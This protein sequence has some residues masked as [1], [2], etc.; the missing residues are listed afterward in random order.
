MG[1]RVPAGYAEVT[2]RFRIVGD[3]EEMLT[4]W[5]I[6]SEFNTLFTADHA[7]QLADVFGTTLRTVMSPDCSFV[8]VHLRGG[9]DGMGEQ[10][11]VD[12]NLPGTGTGVSLPPNNAALIQKRA[13][14]GGRRNRGRN[15]IPGVPAG[16]VNQAGVWA[17]AAQANWQAKATAWLTETAARAFVREVEIFHTT[18]DGI[19]GIPPTPVV[20]V[21]IPNKIATQRR[22]MRP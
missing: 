9:P 2:Y 15:Y 7:A 8:G 3:A 16:V 14:V 1:I 10:F 13:N 22:R 18:P 11:T 19:P 20:S 12:R 4:S 5:G 21:N 6:S 17:A